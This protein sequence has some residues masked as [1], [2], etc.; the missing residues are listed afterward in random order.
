MSEIR[1]P[2]KERGLS[3]RIW[4]GRNS[5]CRSQ[6]NYLSKREVY[7]VD[8]VRNLNGMVSQNNYLS[9]REVYLKGIHDIKTFEK[10]S[11]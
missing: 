4:C 1:L 11:K 9:K 3:L 2:L 7:G 5:A 10:V 8:Y 6:N